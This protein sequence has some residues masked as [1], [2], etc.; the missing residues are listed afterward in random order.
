MSEPLTLADIVDLRTYEREREEFRRTVIALKRLRRL[1]IGPIVSV[2]FENA[3]TMRFQIQEMARAERLGTDAEIQG[4][5]DVYNGLVP[6]QGELSMTLFIELTSEPDLREWLPRLVGIEQSVYARIGSGPDAVRV[7]CVVDEAHA[8]QLTREEV[9]A[10][11]HY[12][13]IVLG[14][15]ERARVVTDELAI[16][17]DHSEYRYETLLAEATKRSLEADWAP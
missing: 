4:E 9:T 2:V 16:G 8:A 7:D 3:K 14:D 5:L 12:V 6:G 17:I 1:A 11:V 15:V 13:R 10:S